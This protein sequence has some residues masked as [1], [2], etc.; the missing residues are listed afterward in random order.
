M[1]GQLLIRAA[2]RRLTGDEDTGEF[3]PTIIMPLDLNEVSAGEVT[4][5]AREGVKILDKSLGV[6]A[7]D[8]SGVT[9]VPAAAV[10]DLAQSFLAIAVDA[11]D[12][13]MREAVGANGNLG[14]LIA[15]AQNRL[16]AEAGQLYTRTI[17]S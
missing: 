10:Y 16:I 14:D 7:G 3:E 12:V 17:R 11:L 5:L 9:T 15:G 4:A 6:G 1:L 8:L 13:A 2:I